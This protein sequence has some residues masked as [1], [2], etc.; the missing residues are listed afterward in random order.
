MSFSNQEAFSSSAGSYPRGCTSRY[1]YNGEKGFIKYGPEGD[2]V[3]RLLHSEATTNGVFTQ[4]TEFTRR[5]K[6]TVHRKV[7]TKRQG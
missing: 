4:W 7:V 3:A 6:P 1:S 2:V 5:G